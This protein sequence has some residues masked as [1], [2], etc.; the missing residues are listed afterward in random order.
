MDDGRPGIDPTD[1][2]R[3]GL[4]P[5]IE[6][7]NHAARLIGSSAL[8]SFQV[9]APAPLCNLAVSQRKCVTHL[10]HHKFREQAQKSL[11]IGPGCMEDQMLEPQIHVHFDFL[12][13]VIR[14]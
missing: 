11:L 4:E 9:K 13:N 14:I 5:H 12:D 6:S 2:R 3:E 10:G 7:K 8:G 1:R